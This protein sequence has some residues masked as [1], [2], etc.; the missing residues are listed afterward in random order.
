MVFFEFM[1]FPLWIMV[2]VFLFVIFLFIFWIWAI[3]D[4]LSSRL[5][6][7]QKLLWLFVIFSFHFIGALLYFIFAK[8]MR[9]KL[10][11]TKN[12][13]GKTLFRSKKNRMIAGVCAGIGDYFSI[14]PTVIRLLWVLITFFSGGVGV[15]AYVIAWIIIP[16]K[17]KV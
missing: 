8:S 7:S 10:M 9:G 11:K 15:L 17:S 2:F 5:S 13:R 3:I 6:A 14:D 4:C 12:L 1:F 16:E